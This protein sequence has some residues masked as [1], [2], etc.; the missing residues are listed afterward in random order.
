M[1][2]VKQLGNGYA[3]IADH[4]PRHLS[5]TTVSQWRDSGSIVHCLEPNINKKK[6][7]NV[8]LPL[9]SDTDMD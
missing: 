7:D 8:G 4:P 1:S 6:V 2:M 3:R 5:S 9:R